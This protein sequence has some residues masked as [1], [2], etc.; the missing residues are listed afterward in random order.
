MLT[1]TEIIFD[2]N[3]LAALLDEFNKWYG[4]ECFY[5]YESIHHKKLK[6][7]YNNYVPQNEP[8]IGLMDNTMFGSASEGCAICK[9]GIFWKEGKTVAHILWSELPTHRPCWHKTNKDR[10][11]FAAYPTTLLINEGK[12]EKALLLFT[13]LYEYAVKLCSEE[14][15]SVDR[16]TLIQSFQEYAGYGHL[17]LEESQLPSASNQVTSVTPSD[18]TAQRFIRILAKLD[19]YAIILVVLLRK[20]IPAKALDLLKKIPSFSPFA[21]VGGLLIGQ[22]VN[23]LNVQ[24]NEVGEPYMMEHLVAQWKI[25]GVEHSKLVS[26]LEKIPEELFNAEVKEE[27]LQLLDKYFINVVQNEKE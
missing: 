20:N 2:A 23:W 27:A 5:I 21:W 10:M 4:K 6:S 16:E 19:G 14:Y 25:N 17:A 24:I 3:C 8:I 7:A 11:M 15:T 18:D 22:A 1:T 12:A 9:K 13:T 26:Q